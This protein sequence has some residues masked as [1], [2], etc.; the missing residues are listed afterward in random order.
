MLICF[1]GGVCTH[2]CICICMPDVVVYDGS[3]TKAC[4][5][6]THT[7]KHHTNPHKQLMFV[8]RGGLS[9]GQFG[10]LNEGLYQHAYSGTKK[11]VERYLEVGTYTHTCMWPRLCINI[12]YMCVYF[13]SRITFTFC[14]GP[15]PTLQT[16][17]TGGGEGPELRLRR[18]PRHGPH[19]HRHQVGLLQRDAPR[20]RPHGPPPLRGRR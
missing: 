12:Y 5:V 10:L 1:L 18:E 15:T 8:L 9:R 19:P 11:I 20:L 13:Y 6:S 7:P 16:P 2:I 17:R 4:L 3:T 14:R